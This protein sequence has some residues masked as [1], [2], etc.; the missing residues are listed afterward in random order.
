LA[1]SAWKPRSISALKQGLLF[2]VLCFSASAGGQLVTVDGGQGMAGEPSGGI[3]GVNFGN[4][5]VDGSLG[6]YNGAIVGGAAA[7]VQLRQRWSLKAGDQ[8]I[9]VAIPTETDFSSGVFAC[10]AALS[11]TPNPATRITLFGGMAGGGYAST[12]VL[13]FT[14]QIPLG[15]LSIDHYLDQKKR[16]L[17]F[18]RAL[19]SNQQTIL[20]GVLYQA[21]R[22]QT[23]FAAGTGSNQPH[24]EAM[25]NYKD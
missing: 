21:K 17:L 25:L 1:R 22:L 7:E 6:V 5:K 20:G 15:A 13:F 9:E 12:S 4:W 24:A 18:G 2:L 16:F 3:V 8:N 10:G 14:P 19:F 23:G 11:Y